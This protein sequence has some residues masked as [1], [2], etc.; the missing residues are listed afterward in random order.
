M[1]NRI[2]SLG[3]LSVIAFWLVW[4][5]GGLWGCSSNGASSPGGSS[6]GVSGDPPAISSDCTVFPADNPWNLDI[7]GEPVDSNSNGYIQFILDHGGDFVHPDFGSN[8][9]YGIPYEIVTGDQALVPV[10]FTDFGDESDPGPYPIPANARVEAGSDGHVLVV[11][12]DN[13]VLY[14]LYVAEKSGSGWNAASGAKFDL[15]SNALR[16][17]GWTSADAAGLPIF[18][19][20]ARYDEAVEQGEIRHAL[21]V[22]FSTT[23]AGYIHPATHKASDETDLNAPPMGLRLRL[24]A[25]YD[26]SHLTG[27]ALVVAEALKKYGMIVADNGSNWY[28]S[29]STDS[30]WNDDDLDQLKSVPGS[31]FE[32]VQ[33]GTIQH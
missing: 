30:R 8:P 11:D 17:D 32:V 26:I 4:T 33:H 14:E 21:R 19:G 1:K 27:A 24:K 16:P 3:L 20:L 7:S 22:T 6:G 28:I 9:D 23:Q 10:T 15:K 5:G 29:G 2:L 13:C 12:Q 31:A 18:A 25:S